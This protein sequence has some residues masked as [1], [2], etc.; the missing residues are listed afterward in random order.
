MLSSVQSNGTS[1]Y[2]AIKKTKKADRTIPQLA[3]QQYDTWENFQRYQH[4]MLKGKYIYTEDVVIGKV[5][6]TKKI[7]NLIYAQDYR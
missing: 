4:L 1:F 6:A 3:P 2:N 7:L 5:M